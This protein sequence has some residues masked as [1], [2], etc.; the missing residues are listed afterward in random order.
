MLKRGDQCRVRASTGEIIE[1]QYVEPYNYYEKRHWVYTTQCGHMITGYY[2]PEG[3][4][5][6]RFVG[7][8]C[9]LEVIP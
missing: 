8:P 6:C 9:G 7:N 3:N 2:K 5:R 1:A 4:F